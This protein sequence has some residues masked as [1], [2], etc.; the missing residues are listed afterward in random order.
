MRGRAK[1]YSRHVQTSLENEPFMIELKI[2]VTF[3]I[4]NNKVVLFIKCFP[5]QPVSKWYAKETLS[6]LFAT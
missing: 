5:R 1:K 6:E 2:V 3:L 4:V